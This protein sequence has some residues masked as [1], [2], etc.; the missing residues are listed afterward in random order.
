MTRWGWVL[1][2]FELFLFELILIRPD[3]DLPDTAFRDGNSP[4]LAKL[5]VTTAPVM[6]AGL[7]RLSTGSPHQNRSC[8]SEGSTVVPADRSRPFCDRSFAHC[9]ASCF[10]P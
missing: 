5:Q 3:V 1:P 7:T 2:I 10:S 6:A 8:Y 4:V 9:C